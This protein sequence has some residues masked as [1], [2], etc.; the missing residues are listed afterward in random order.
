MPKRG[1]H[2]QDAIDTSKPKGHEKSPGPNRPGRSQR[3]TTGTYKKQETYRQRAYAH[4]EPEPR[5]AQSAF[6]PWN[7]DLREMPTIQESPRARHSD[8][9]RG[10]SGSDSNAS[11][12]TRGY[13]SGSLQGGRSCSP[14]DG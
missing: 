9:T 6:D 7:P 5:P 11:R 8:I 3:I 14:H 13:S 1:Q 10:R 12:R 2:K 4:Q